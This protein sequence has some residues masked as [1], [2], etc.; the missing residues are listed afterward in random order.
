VF[1]DGLARIVIFAKRTIRPCEELCYDYQLPYEAIDKRIL[2]FCGAAG[3][4]GWLNWADKRERSSQAVVVH[5]PISC[6]NKMQLLT[7]VGALTPDNERLIEALQPLLEI[8]ADSFVETSDEEEDAGSE[9][10]SEAEP[11]ASPPPRVARGRPR[12]PAVVAPVRRSARLQEKEMRKR[13]VEQERLEVE[14]RSAT[15][16][17]IDDS[18]QAACRHMQLSGKLWV[19]RAR[20]SGDAKKA[21]R[22]KGEEEAA[23]EQ[24]DAEGGRDNLETEQRHVRAAPVEAALFIDVDGLQRAQG[25]MF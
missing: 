23:A 14:S 25:G 7:D 9:S 16:R 4:K 13:E 1:H 12:P 18:D 22:G 20:R 5:R 17:V 10:S 3:C 21:A 19:E 24:S 15:V 2:C 6:E 8:D 11:A